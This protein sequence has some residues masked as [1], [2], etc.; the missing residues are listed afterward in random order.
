MVSAILTT[1]ALNSPSSSIEFHGILGSNFIRC[2]CFTITGRPIYAVPIERSRL[3]KQSTSIGPVRI[4][5]SLGNAIIDKKELD[6]KPSFDEYL[7]VMESVKENKKTVGD[8]SERVGQNRDSGEPGR[9][10]RPVEKKKAL[11]DS[12]SPKSGGEKIQIQSRT[13]KK[14]LLKP[15]NDN[16]RVEE[17]NRVELMEMDRAAFKSMEEYGEDDAYDKPRVSKAEMEERIQMLARNLNGADIDMPEWKFS[18]MMRSAKIRF[19]DHSMSRIIQILGKLGN[20]RRVL[21]V[22]EWI[23]SRERFI[24]YRI[25][26]I[27]NAALDA[28]GK[29]KRPVEA[30]NL[31]HEMQEDVSSYPDLV[32]YHSIAVTLGQA[33]HMEELFYVIESMRSP[34]K[35]KLKT[36]ILEKWDPRLEP[37]NIIYNAVL[38]ACVNCKNWEGALWVLQQ[39]KQQG[40]QPS[41]VTYGLVMEV[42]LAC[43]KYN[44]VHDYFIKLQKSCIPSALTYKVLINTLWKEGKTDEAILAVEDME[45]RGIVGTASLYYDL[46]RCL[47]SA[48]RWQEALIQVDKICKVATKPLVV[49]YTGLIKACID[50]GDVQS[51]VYVFNHMHNFCSPNLITYN[52]LLK[53]YLDHELFEEAKQLY[54]LANTLLLYVSRLWL[55][56]LNGNRHRI[57]SDKLVALLYELSMCSGRTENVLLENLMAS[58]KEFLS[59]HSDM[60]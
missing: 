13:V 59:T 41:S 5:C 53:A 14:S 58:C 20:W 54:T 2:P 1:Q 19:S 38:N 17:R 16:P 49:T 27:Y 56:F 26:Y 57:E 4:A 15:N 48:G 35:K 22:I 46:A 23:Q 7:K 29:A 10:S 28:L 36:G 12:M 50:S 60:A 40:Q 52:I 32:S 9:Q 25:R 33:G 42:M 47:C 11:S 8:R 55:Q 18:E 44:L 45:R 39:L 21:Q 43:G 6:F 24:S 51:G 31:F 30:L 34:P 37:D 3:K